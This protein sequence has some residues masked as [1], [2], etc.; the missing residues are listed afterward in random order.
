MTT[1]SSPPL[2]PRLPRA[3]GLWLR[4]H[5]GL[6]GQR[7]KLGN[8][9]FETAARTVLV[10]DAYFPLARREIDVLEVLLRKQGQTVP[11][12]II[13]DAIYSIEEAPGPN[14]LEASIS[15]LRRQLSE[16]GASV[17]IHTIRA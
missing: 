1:S 9:T 13:E 6:L 7:I 3:A 2:R 17:E 16:A 10:S 5:G 14:A 4:R 8:L 15:R 11:R 12:R